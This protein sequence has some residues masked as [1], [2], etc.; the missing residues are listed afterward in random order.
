LVGCGIPFLAPGQ[1]IRTTPAAPAGIRVQNDSL[2][3]NYINI[4]LDWQLLVNGLPR[5]KGT[6]PGLQLPPGRPRT[7]RLPLRP[8]APADEAWLKVEYRGPVRTRPPLAGQTFR[9]K[10]WA[11][12]THIPA[13]G[14]LVFTD[15]ND[16]FTISSP[17]LQI[18]FDKQTG[19]IQGYSVDHF[20]LLSDSNGLRP[21]L[22]APPHLQLFSTSTG[23]QMAIVR[24]EYT[25][26][27][28]SCLLH[29]S[30]TLNAAGTLLV[31]Q[32]LETDTTRGDS[33]VHP[34]DRFG[35]NWNLATAFD[36]VASY[37]LATDQDTFP[38][39][40][41]EPLPASPSAMIRWWTI[42]DRDGKGFQLTA[43]SNF[44]CR[45]S[46]S[47]SGKTLLIDGPLPPNPTIPVRFHYS[48]KLSPLIHR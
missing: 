14:E 20:P 39:L 31:E 38:V 25:L 48:F 22:P 8:L 21:A 13:A 1:A 18:S 23:P 43:D 26:P 34:I 9:W 46:M 42:R 10:T 11:G 5:Q 35:M 32:I 4:T 2:L 30:Y 12:D 24:T 3:K 17:I 15:S 6:V 47:P 27:E 40:R 33:V 28:L 19:W 41:A 16:L 29:L 7:I 36:S 45:V 44:L 37:G